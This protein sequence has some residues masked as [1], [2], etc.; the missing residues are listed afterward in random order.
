MKLGAIDDKF[1]NLTGML[2]TVEGDN[3]NTFDT[4]FDNIQ[5][6][7]NSLTQAQYDANR[8]QYQNVTDAPKSRS[9]RS[10]AS[11]GINYYRYRGQN[12]I[13]G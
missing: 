1:S 9:S 6:A 2:E 8:N 11:W 4:K 10:D 7:S 5:T 3:L 13:R 12:E